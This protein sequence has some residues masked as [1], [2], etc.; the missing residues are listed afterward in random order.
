VHRFLV[1]NVPKCG[2]SFRELSH[3]LKFQQ[4]LLHLQ[5]EISGNSNQI[6]GSDEKHLGKLHW[7]KVAFFSA[8]RP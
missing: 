2:Y 1:G 5:M 8:I 4:I 3:F 6:F 7:L